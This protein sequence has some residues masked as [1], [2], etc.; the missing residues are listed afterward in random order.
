MMRYIH[1]KE[2]DAVKE[3]HIVASRKVKDRWN[4]NKETRNYLK[5]MTIK[6]SQIWVCIRNRMMKGVE[7]NQKTTHK[8]NLRCRFCDKGEE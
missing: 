5:Y 1:S 6:N 8:V 2:W 7:M 3:A 4:E